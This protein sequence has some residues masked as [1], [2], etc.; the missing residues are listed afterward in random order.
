MEKAIKAVEE[1]KIG[2]YKA[3]RE[4]NVPKTTLRQYLKDSNKFAK[5]GNNILLG[6]STDLPEE[7]EQQLVNHILQMKSGFMYF[8]QRILRN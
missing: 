2:L 5:S 4:F 7:M 1:K 8:K 6:R 3:S